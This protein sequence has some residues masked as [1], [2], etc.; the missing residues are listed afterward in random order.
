MTYTLQASYPHAP[1]RTMTTTLDY[2]STVIDV[3]PDGGTHTRQRMLDGDPR[4]QAIR[5]RVADIWRDARGVYVRPTLLTLGPKDPGDTT[6]G[7]QP[8]LA[9]VAPE[10][11]V[12]VGG[13]W[14]E[15]ITQGDDT[16]SIEVE[17]LAR[18]GDHVRQR[19]TFHST[20]VMWGFPATRDGT[21]MEE[22]DLSGAEG[23]LHGDIAFV[24]Q[25]RQGT[26]N[27]TG[28]LDVVTLP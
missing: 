22:F 3:L 17:L 23:S 14:H 28:T 10:E 7:A 9:T 19:V 16:A 18:D 5:G 8:E 26:V 2:E 27:A 24:V 12:G 15:D 6:S 1:P 20:G 4:T 21:M 25:A 11:P 13:R